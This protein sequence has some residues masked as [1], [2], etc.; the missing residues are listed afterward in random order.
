MGA[1]IKALLK[2]RDWTIYRAAAETG[3]STGH[4]HDLLTGKY[5]PGLDTLRRLSAG[6][7]VKISDFV[8]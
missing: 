6:F 4:L 8:D 2:Q 5:K 3:L 7:G 1:K